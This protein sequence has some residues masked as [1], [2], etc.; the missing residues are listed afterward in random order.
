MAPLM[1][2]GIFAIVGGVFALYRRIWG[3]ALA[4]MICLVAFSLVVIVRTDLTSIGIIF[5][6]IAATGILAMILI[7]KSKGEFA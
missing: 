7:A 4:G 3:L 6:I 5:G 2:I 1:L